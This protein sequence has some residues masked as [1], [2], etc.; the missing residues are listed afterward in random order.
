MNHHIGIAVSGG[1][2]RA[3][4]WALGVTKALV[5]N[6]LNQRVTS[7]TSV[8]GGSIANGYIA[9]HLDYQG[10]TPENFET[11]TGPL[12]ELIGQK[13]L[14]LYGPATDRYV[15]GTLFVC[16]LSLAS[17]WTA[18][19]A[20]LSAGH[21]HPTLP[22]GIAALA[23]LLIASYGTAKKW[24]H[25]SPAWLF[26]LTVLLLGAAP[27]GTFVGAIGAI[28]IAITI[29][30]T[31]LLVLGSVVLLSRRGVAVTK[32]L[33]TLLQNPLANIDRPIDHIF[34]AADLETADALYLSPRFVSSYRR[35][36]TTP[37]GISLAQAVQASAA[38]PAAFPPSILNVSNNFMGARPASDHNLRHEPTS[39]RLPLSDGGAY[40]NMGTQWDLGRAQRIQRWGPE[41]PATLGPSPTLLIVANG[42]APFEWKTWKANN[43]ITRETSSLTRNQ[44]IQYDQTTTTRRQLLFKT[45]ND[46][47]NTGDGLG[48]IIIMINRSP[49]Y[50]CDEYA[51][52]P[53]SPFHTRALEM[54]SA[55]ATAGDCPE[56][57]CDH[58]DDTCPVRQSWKGVVAHNQAVPTTLT[59]I[60][61]DTTQSLIA[62]ARTATI[63]Y[64]FVLHQLADPTTVDAPPAR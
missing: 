54:R 18:L 46:Y 12:T 5:D 27:L 61:A 60:G 51:E 22:Y 16:I 24:P 45:F 7:I 42:S 11:A 41:A 33:Q 35:G 34:V 44:A 56:S 58:S 36:I 23:T 50:I 39:K 4:A 30:V 10:A 17:V 8:S 29:G 14:F 6:E 47:Q 32:A 64:L 2:H 53:A 63:A 9:E 1:G 13:G 43:P 57:E 26:A 15:I 59:K 38:L 31:L 20:I 62:H 55:L 49:F 19:T 28:A 48:G 52:D 3:T 40:D 21:D 25:G 37:T